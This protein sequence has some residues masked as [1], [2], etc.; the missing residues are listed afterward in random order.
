MSDIQVGE[1]CRTKQG[2]IAKL[3]KK[4]IDSNIKES[5]MTFNDYIIGYYGSGYKRIYEDDFDKITKHSFNIIDLIEEGDYVNG[6][7]VADV[8]EGGV[9]YFDEVEGQYYDI[10]EI[11]S[12]VTKERFEE[13]EY[14]VNE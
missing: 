3:I 6:L 14:K 2:K 4:G 12:I 9:S 10:G 11:K 7:K 5:Y 1:Y 13:V 8:N